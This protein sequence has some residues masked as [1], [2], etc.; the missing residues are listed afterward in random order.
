MVEIVPGTVDAAREKH[1]PDIVKDGSVIKI[2]VGSVEHPMLDAH[3][4]D[5]VALRTKSGCQVKKLHAGEEPRV[6]FAILP[7]DEIVEV[8]AKLSDLMQ[9]LPNRFVQCHKS[10]VVNMGFIKELAQDHALLTTGESVPIS[11]QRRKPMR[12]AFIEY[13][14]KA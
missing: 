13:I 2:S 5:F 10:Y 7:D 12:E 1:I 6:S 8:Y 14:G 4:I 9:K 3:Y 11:Q